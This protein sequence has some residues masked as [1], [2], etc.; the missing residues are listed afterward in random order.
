[1]HN[2]SRYADIGMRDAW[3]YEYFYVGKEYLDAK[4]I[5]TIV[6]RNWLID[7][8]IID[9][10]NNI[11]ELGEQLKNM[12]NDSD[13]WNVIL[14][15]LYYNSDLIRWYIDDVE[16]NDAYTRRELFTKLV[17]Y[18]TSE[19]VYYRESTVNGAIRALTNMVE[20]TPIVGR[21]VKR[22][23]VKFADNVSKKV[24][25]YSLYKAAEYYGRRDF[26][27]TELYSKDFVG[28]PYKLFGITRDKLER[29][30]RGLQ[31]EEQLVKV[32]LV[33]DLDNISLREDITSLDIVKLLKK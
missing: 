16:W 33:A 5:R 26:T 8:G 18:L 27:V 31:E 11:T 15:N 2:L 10:N 13:I 12:R 1:M 32:D 20:H 29:A 23:I 24:V 6:I 7:A 3:L 30:L 28:G 21:V 19:Q 9:K 14:T 22:A 17:R 25:A 4:D